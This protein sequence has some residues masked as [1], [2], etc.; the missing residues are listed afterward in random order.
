[1]TFRAFLAILASPSL[2]VAPMGRHAPVGRADKTVTG[3]LAQ[4]P[5]R[6]RRPSGCVHKNRHRAGRQIIEGQQHRSSIESDQ[7]GTD[8]KAMRETG[9]GELLGDDNA[10]GDKG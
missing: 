5:I 10:I 2:S 9:L 3:P 4:A 8:A 7:P 1:M 6:S